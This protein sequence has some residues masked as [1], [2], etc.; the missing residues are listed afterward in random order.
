MRFSTHCFWFSSQAREATERMRQGADGSG[1]AN[2][3]G[4]E[5]HSRNGRTDPNSDKN[6]A[7]TSQRSATSED[8]EGQRVVVELAAAAPGD[9]FQPLDLLCLAAFH[10]DNGAWSDCL[11]VLGTAQEV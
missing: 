7:R 9:R 11:D 6:G 2:G 4:S 3:D 10:A 8:P 5:R 1:G